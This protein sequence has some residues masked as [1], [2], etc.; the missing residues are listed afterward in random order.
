MRNKIFLTG[1]LIIFLFTLTGCYDASTIEDSYYIVAMSIDEGKND[2]YDISIQIAK[3]DSSSSGSN[4]NSSQSS[5]YTIYK[6]QASTIDNGISILNNY[7]NKK[8]NLSH[9]SAIVFSE[10]LAKKGIGTLLNTLANNHEIRPNTYVLIS[11]KKASDVLEKVANSKEKFSSRFYEYVINS[12]DYTGYSVDTNFAELFSDVNNTSTDAVAI[13]TS[14]NNETI[15]NNGLAI[16]KDDR[17]VGHTNA[18]ESI[19]HLLL[20]NKLEESLITFDN[21]FENNSK[22]DL[23][24]SI[25]KDNIINVDIINNSPFITCEIFVD[26]NIQT[27]GKNFDY[28]TS[29]NIEAVEKTAEKYL[30]TLI[31]DYLY[32]LSKEYNAD[33]LNFQNI[34]SKQCLTNSE[35]EKVHFDD[36]YKESFFDVTVH[37]SIAS[38]H[39][40]DRE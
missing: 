15:Q 19:A 40:F 39:L 30:K 28:T 33:V 18:L 2:F 37:V 7:L 29:K 1:I 32:T 27:S 26:G 34:Y 31:T 24:L 6:V 14:V 20:I 25:M 5:E 11:S 9:C 21:P 35:L 13:Y 8:I 22:I 12:L 36:I 16:F 17:M 10:D 4:G 23:D 38:T 3:N